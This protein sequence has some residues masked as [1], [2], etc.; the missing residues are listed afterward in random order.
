MPDR[1]FRLRVL[2]ALTAS[3]EGISVAAGYQH[4]LAGAVF[5]GRAWFTENQDPLPMISILEQPSPADLVAVPPSAAVTNVVDYTLLIQGFVRDDAVHPTDPAYL[6]LADVKRKLAAE[7]KV[8][9][10]GSHRPDPFGLNPT[11]KAPNRIEELRIGAGVVRPA[12][13]VSANAYFWLMLVLRLVEN[14]ENPF[15]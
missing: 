13:D 2:D 6:L 14:D 3:L 10:T 4:D 5:R 15:A 12:D 9:A 8:R 1:P 7:R 11:G